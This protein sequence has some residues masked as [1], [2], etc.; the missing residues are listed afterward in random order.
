[1]KKVRLSDERRIQLAELLCK[2]LGI[3]TTE[4]DNTWSMAE[5]INFDAIENE[6]WL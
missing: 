2:E 3:D 1:M 4:D 5:F 6:V